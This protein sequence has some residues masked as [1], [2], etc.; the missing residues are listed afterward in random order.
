MALAG[1][2]SVVV[3][4]LFIVAPIVCGVF[5]LVP[6]SV[7]QYFNVLSSFYSLNSGMWLLL[8]LSLPRCRGLVC[9]VWLLHFL[10]VL[11]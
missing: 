10:V 1:G 8:I 6:C 4:S 9:S 5:V 2:G 7:M 3:Y 11:T